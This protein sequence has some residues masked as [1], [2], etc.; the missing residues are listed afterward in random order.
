[1]IEKFNDPSGGFYDTPVDGENLLVRPK[2]FQDNATPSG[3]ALASEALLKLVAFTKKTHYRDLAEKTL[4][5]AAES[6]LRF[7]TVFARWFSVAELA[8]GNGKQIA[9]LGNHDINFEVMLKIIRSDYRPEWVVAAS[10]YPPQ[11]HTPVSISRQ[12]I[13]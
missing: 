9:L 10:V 7:P 3:N 12:T 11:R 1:M 4:G 2:D 6:A 13:G 5:L 8:K